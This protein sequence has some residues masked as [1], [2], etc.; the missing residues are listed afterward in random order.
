MPQIERF[1][2][3]RSWQKGRELCRLVYTATGDGAFARDYGLRD[4]MRRAAVSIL[5]NIAEGFESQNNKTFTRYLYIAR[6][7]AAEVRSQAYIAL[8]Q[9]YITEDTFN[10]LYSL[11]KDVARLLTRFIRYLEQHVGFRPP[12]SD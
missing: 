10:R 3:I 11:S 8:D 4:Q 1:E 12:P 7:S 2:D 6:G 5:S 9:G